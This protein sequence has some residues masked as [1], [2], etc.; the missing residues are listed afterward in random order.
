MSAP[1]GSAVKSILTPTC[2]PRRPGRNGSRVVENLEFP[3]FGRR[4]L[5]AAGRRV[6]AGDVDA[7]PALSAE[8]GTA[9]THAVTELRAAG[10]RWAEIAVRLGVT[11]QAAHQRWAGTA[12]PIRPA[13][14]SSARAVAS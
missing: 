3:A 13:A 10:Y 14:A 1:T 9:I 5:R 7:L 11:R 12:D 4:V 6:A 8:L 2:T